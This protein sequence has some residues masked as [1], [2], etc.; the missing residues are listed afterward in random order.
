MANGSNGTSGGSSGVVQQ[1]AGRVI[2]VGS[3]NMDL[4][5]RSPRLPRPGETVLGGPFARFSGGKG[6][7]QAVAAARLC[8]E[9]GVEMLGAVGD[10][11]HG[12][13][14]RDTLLEHRVGLGALLTRGGPPT[15]VALITIDADGENTIVVAGGANE[16]VD[17]ADIDGA[18]DPLAIGPADVVLA[19]LETPVPAVQRAAARARAAGARF[20]LNAAPAPASGLP[21]ELLERTTVLI[22][23]EHEAAALSG[24]PEPGAAARWLLNAGLGGGAGTV[25]V[26]LGARGALLVDRGGERAIPPLRVE[27]VDTVGAGDCFCGALAARLVA[28]DDAAAAAGFACRAAALAT[29]RQGAIAGMPTLDEVLAQGDE[30]PPP[31]FVAAAGL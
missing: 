29:T 2:V 17:E 18:M 3:L 23:N 1:G 8:G 20:L 21:P 28:G 30:P 16:T 24:L 22:V 13:T 5:V 26:T 9:H 25:A 12:A 7:N 11:E 31:G 15:G 14:L 6:A 4:V 27:A 10:D 19:V